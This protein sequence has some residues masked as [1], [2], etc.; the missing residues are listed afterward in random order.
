MPGEFLFFKKKNFNFLNIVLYSIIINR[1]CEL[2]Y[3]S[4]YF[5][6]VSWIK[7]YEFLCYGLIIFTYITKYNKRKMY[8]D[9]VSIVSTESRDIFQ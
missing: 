5:L 1:Q 2:T 6:H 3:K 8:R 9:N 7:L 4:K